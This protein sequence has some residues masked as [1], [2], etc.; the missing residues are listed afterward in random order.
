MR[1]GPF[2]DAARAKAAEADQVKEKLTGLKK[3]RPRDEAAIAEAESQLAALNKESREAAA[4]AEAIENAVYD[5]KA[6]NP[7][8]KANADTRTPGQL[9]DLIEAKGREITEAVGVLRQR[10]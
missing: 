3:A 2:R 9:L 8:R 1:V 7:N 4:K 10:K 6:V 5:L